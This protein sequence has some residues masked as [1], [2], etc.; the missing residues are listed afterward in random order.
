MKSLTV[1][2]EE[3]GSRLD[4]ALAL[5]V[6]GMGLRGR[7]RLCELG[8]ARV[9]GRPAAASYKVRAGEALSLAEEGTEE[10]KEAPE[11]EAAA[12]ADGPRLIARGKN[13]AFLYKP[14]GMHS[15]S[16]AGKPGDSLQSRLEALLGGKAR[17]LNRLDFATSGIVTAAL[18]PAGKEEYQNAQDRGLTEKRYLALLE[19]SLPRPVLADGKLLLK[20]RERVLVELARHPDARRHTRIIPLAVMEARPVLERLAHLWQGQAPAA[21]TLAGCIIL[22]GARHQIRA[23]CAAQ[24]FPLAGDG[25]YGALFRP[26]EGEAFFLHHGRLILPGISA[27]SLPPW[28]EALGEEAAEKA[29]LW[30]EA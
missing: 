9:N 4:R 28:L 20:N 1:T 13:L 29:R 19:G 18:S 25:R 30:L 21:L 8:L 6:P 12:P 15:E 3:E 17:L 23:H 22:K 16:L 5:L 2:Q 10:G 11:K 24:G 27:L 26:E 14:S 7:R